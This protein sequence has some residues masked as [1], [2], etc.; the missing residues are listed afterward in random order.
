MISMQF[1]LKF[2]RLSI[3]PINYV[4][5]ATSSRSATL[6]TWS[7]KMTAPS[8]GFRYL[9]FFK[10]PFNSIYL[11]LCCSPRTI[12]HGKIVL[13]TKSN[14]PSIWRSAHCATNSGTASKTTSWRRSAICA[15]ISPTSGISSQCKLKNR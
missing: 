3:L 2:Q 4:N 14:T 13:P 8:I 6:R 11:R 7:L 1:L 5:M 15:R 9:L 12:G 10:F